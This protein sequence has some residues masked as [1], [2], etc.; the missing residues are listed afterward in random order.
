MMTEADQVDT[1]GPVKPRADFA[2]FPDP[3]FVPVWARSP[4]K[5]AQNLLE[6]SDEPIEYY[7]D[8]EDY[9][10][11]YFYFPEDCVY[12]PPRRWSDD[13]T[14]LSISEPEQDNYDEMVPALPNIKMLDVTALTDLISG[15]LS[16]P[17]IT[18]IM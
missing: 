3:N 12:H 11:N 6:C 8:D 4:I 16:A 9:K 14:D 10:D 2:W 7:D 15:N 18:T 13:T 5:Y 1:T 17:E